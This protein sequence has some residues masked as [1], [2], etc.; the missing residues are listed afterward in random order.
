M[1]ST[2]LPP[3]FPTMFSHVFPRTATFTL[4]QLRNIGRLSVGKFF[5]G[6]GEASLWSAGAKSLYYVNKAGVQTVIAEGNF[7]AGYAQCA[8]FRTVG[9]S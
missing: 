7:A 6:V 3:C 2:R 9:G 8:S 5:A 4:S 1:H